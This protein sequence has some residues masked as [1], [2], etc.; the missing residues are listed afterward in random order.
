MSSLEP[1]LV[2]SL[3]LIICQKVWIVVASLVEK[4]SS[5]EDLQQMH[6]KTR[7]NWEQNLKCLKAVQSRQKSEESLV[8][9]KL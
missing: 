9:R 8:L 7:Q 4:E 5:Q 2:K 3:V 6:V 1:L